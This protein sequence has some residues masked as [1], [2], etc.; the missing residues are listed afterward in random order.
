MKT[1]RYLL[2]IALLVAGALPAFSQVSNDNEDEVY[3]IDA[4]AGM[5]DFVPGQVLV[6]FKDES[7]MNVSKARGRF[8]SAGN[9]AVDVVL[10]EFGV[11][12]M[13][14]LLP[15][16]TPNKVRRKARGYNG[17]MVEEKDL[18]QLY[19]VK[20]NSLRRDSTMMLVD[21]LADLG[22][23]EYAEPNY[24]VY[25]MGQVPQPIAAL[26]T[27]NS[28]LSDNTNATRAADDVIC[29]N[30][31]QNPLFTQQWGITALNINA[32]WNK[33]IVNKKRPVIAILDTGVDITHPNLADNIWINP[34]EGEGETAY[35]DDDNGFV[36][37]L[38]GWNFVDRNAYTDDKAM[39]GTHVAG[40]AAATDNGVGIVGAN[41]QALIM[42]VK[43]LNDA[44]QGNTANLIEGINYA[45][46]NGADVINMSIGGPQ[47]LSLK[48]ALEKAY[49]TAVL[50]AAA[51]ND[52]CN[53]YAM[54]NCNEAASYPAAYSVVL[55]VMATGKS[56][57][58]TG[59]SNFDPDGP[60]FSEDG[61][62]GRNYELRAPG[63]DGGL[64]PIISTV[65]GGKYA[66][67]CGTS[68]AAPLVS[69]AISALKMVKDYVSN[70]VMNGD[71][72]HLDCD[73]A[74]I[75]SDDT[76]RYPY[77]DFCA[78]DYDD[79]KEGGNGDGQID[80]GETV[81]LYPTLVSSWATA[82]NIKLHLDVDPLYKEKVIVKQNDVSLGWSLSA[83]GRAKS[84]N[85]LVISV[86]EKMADETT[87]KLFLTMTCD[88]AAESFKYDFPITIHSTT[89]IGGILDRDTTF[90]ADKNYIIT[91]NLAIPE[92]VTLT[93]EPGTKLR[94]KAGVGISSE[95]KLII[96][97][98][99][100]KPIIMTSVDEEGYWLFIK[101]SSSNTRDTLKYCQFKNPYWDG[102]DNPVCMDC[103]FTDIETSLSYSLI[104]CNIVYNSF[105]F[106][107]NS[108]YFESNVID[109]YIDFNDP[110][111]SWST[112]E[113]SNYFNCQNIN[114]SWGYGG[115]IMSEPYLFW[116]YS[117]TPTIIKS[118]NPPYV[119]T[120]D[121]KRAN[122]YIRDIDYDYGFAQ[123]D[124]SNMRKEPVKEAHGIVWKVLVNGK[125]A[126]DEYDEITPLGVGKHKFE[127]Y[128]NRPMNKAKTP[129]VAFGL[130]SPY[131]QHA[132]A[133][134]GSWNDEG[135]IY[136][137]Y[138]T[139]DART[140][141]DGLNRIYVD[142]AEDNEYFE[143]PYE[144]LRFNFP[145]QSAGSM[146]TGF[147]GSAGVGRV[148]LEWNND[149]NDF[150]DAMGFN[151]YRYTISEEGKADTLCI[152]D[153]V[154]D[155]NTNEYIDYNVIPGE[156][157]YYY[158]KVLS[159]DLQEFDV[160]NV[161]AV[162]PLT[163]TRG[164]A[165]GSG[166]VDVA[167]VIT[168]VNYAA[169]MDPKPFIFEAADMN[170]DQVIDI[171]DVVGIIQGI[172]NP[173][174]LTASSVGAEATYSIEDGILY[175]DCP[176][177]LAGVQVM[178]SAD[179]NQKITVADDL[180]GF[181]QTSAW[182][183][184]NDYLFMAYNMSGKSLTPG[185]HAL[186]KIND[187][188]VAGIK[189]ADIAGRNVTTLGIDGGEATAISRTAKDMMNVKGVYDIKG[190]KIAGSVEQMK[191]ELPKGVYIIDG[192][193]VVK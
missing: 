45:A 29:P 189:L 93:V 72:M 26:P 142:G 12:T 31:S 180:K 148:N 67:M 68:M 185:K 174:L 46:E 73:F 97:G 124:L 54:R 160:S 78:V 16:E 190:Q 122:T 188:D 136:T 113:K 138:F 183:S 176:V 144:N 102:G 70:D 49:Q 156:T 83:Y 111:P 74:K 76:P 187:A 105:R 117:R 52:G 129:N 6:K 35:D 10:K 193:K 95:G 75:V 151:V 120:S 130:R 36:D 30:P 153:G 110:H 131:T 59:Y 170:T 147:M 43:V 23:V 19:I 9:N 191:R 1:N 172:L 118:D 119:G 168:T 162:T 186:L 157:Y 79:S 7:P 58:L 140:Q 155:I 101:T 22:E 21:K 27:I 182:L 37:D 112:I 173:S 84:A 39:H 125:D 15:N 87:V 92:G 132:V 88:D 85:P 62:D 126:Q 32:L 121:E 4:R 13:D 18:S 107:N 192:K 106:N 167:D 133:E 51:G 50:V 91:N 98:T 56:G 175:V 184:D 42:V 181:E 25:M 17:E 34:R 123:V 103:V 3:K 99:P 20:T 100:E 179:K 77:L 164:D 64:S 55:G 154:L 2:G 71:L 89:M 81:E 135:T 61:I 28:R 11:E 163:S 90:T 44:G 149:G 5:N 108:N 66:G 104:R 146:A 48:L 177:A 24:K 65:P 114:T 127:V 178:L 53:I 82:R 94:F 40:I 96:H 152:N 145:L 166:D 14:K 150:D 158:Y 115:R 38:H 33:P 47:S 86:D 69:G 171:L 80:V 161:V 165:N 57:D 159:T 60:M 109:N 134:D 143:C 128:F 139:V 141:S 8:R 63:G 116:E 41:P 169:G 137:A